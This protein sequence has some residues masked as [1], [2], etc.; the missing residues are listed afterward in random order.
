MADILPE[1][2][3]EQK[4]RI[5]SDYRVAVRARQADLAEKAFQADGKA[6][7]C[8]LAGGQELAQITAVRELRAG[9]WVRGYYRSGAEVLALG[10]LTVRQMIA[11]VIGDT[12]GMRDPSSGGRMMGRHPGSRLLDEHGDPVNF[13]NQVNRASDVS[14][15]SSQ[16]P[17]AVGLARAS[18]VFRDVPGLQDPKFSS[19]SHGGQ[20]V[21]LVSIG[22]ASMAEG[23]AYEAIAQAVVQQLPLVVSVM[24]NGYGISVPGDKQIPHGSVS[25][26]LSG[27]AANDDAQ[28]GLKM[29][30]PVSGW[31]YPAL[32][33]AYQSAFEWV[34]S[35]RG[36][37]L[38][39][40][41][42][43]QPF[44]HSSSGDHA[45]YKTPERLDYDKNMD[46]IQH[47]RAWMIETGLSTEAEL[48]TLDADEMQYVESEAKAAWT[49]YYQT[50]VDEASG[51]VDLYDRIIMEIPELE[52]FVRAEIQS[53]REK[54]T[55][56]T[57]SRISRGD[58]IL[59]MRS[60]L[61][62]A[63][64]LG[65]DNNNSV[66]DL[67]ALFQKMMRD[68][69]EAYSSKVYAE[70]DKSPLNAPHIPPQYSESSE[71]DTSAHV[72][73]AGIATFMR[74]DPRV[75]L[76]GE[77]TGKIGGVVT[78]TLGL[79]GGHNSIIP[80]HLKGSPAIREHVPSEGFGES[81]SW[82][83]AIAESTIVGTAVGLSLR[84]L[85]PIAEIQYHD[86]VVWGL[87]QMV[88]E[89]SSLRHRTDGGQ[90]AP[91]LLRT[92]GHQ[93]LGM[94]HSGSPMGM[95][96][97]SCPG[98][99]VLVPRDGVQAVAMYRAVLQGGDPAF[100]VEPLAD[101]WSKIPVPTNLDEVSIPLGQSE[102]LRPGTDVTIVT[103]GHN[104]YIALEAARSLQEDG[105]SVEV[106][107]LQTL[108]P[109]DVNGE[110]LKSIQKTGKVLFLDEDVPNGAMSMVQKTLINDRGALFDIETMDVLTAPEH[111][112]PYGADG[113]FFGKPQPHDV[114]DRIFAMLDGL[115]NGNRHIS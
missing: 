57:Q 50:I 33:T 36:P 73:S 96:L 18:H 80:S 74:D 51:V 4:N 45:R 92:H 29:I 14:S 52:D 38:V 54:F 37:A 6:K 62:A 40:T 22:D 95:V 39:H 112:P 19:L 98:L 5:L 47:M 48:A 70:G 90:Q 65:F 114:C 60:V 107:D 25:R 88:D 68:G 20:E 55:I 105:V 24:D 84:G 26:S 103:Y 35:G 113:K 83:H 71:V 93:F 44:G 28:S 75:V 89:L 43:T 27:F 115:D 109:L 108:S 97:A 11:Q 2:D 10:T 63:K 16:M 42:V 15:T 102:V 34:R 85:K 7:F 100:S 78:S 94:W 87:Q 30:G 9:D 32:R 64:K 76:Y 86:Y 8:I 61:R 53:F 67:H 17:V 111:K 101:L 79:Q 3:P 31:D 77:D 21:A 41:L 12:T 13:M 106:V 66:A 72:I 69:K 99:R 81:R 23:T 59:S 110:A 58:M 91:A 82:D 1:L 49:D 104:C 56:D 46:G